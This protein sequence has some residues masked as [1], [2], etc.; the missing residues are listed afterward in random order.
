[1]R[2]TEER[3]WQEN[4]PRFTVISLAIGVYPSDNRRQVN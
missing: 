3:R 1:M 4:I 2:N